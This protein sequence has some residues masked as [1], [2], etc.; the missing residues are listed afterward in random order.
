MD[1]SF[2]YMYVSP[3]R[4]SKAAENLYKFGWLT[5]TS[6]KAISTGKGIFPF[7][8]EFTGNNMEKVVFTRK[9]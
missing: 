3:C 6:G 5:P 1:C 4:S 2:M 9:N 7:F 8:P